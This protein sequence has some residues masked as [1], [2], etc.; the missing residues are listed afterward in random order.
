MATSVKNSTRIAGVAR[1]AVWRRIIPAGAVAMALL[2]AACGSSSSSGSA[3]GPIK[4][5]VIF[6]LS[7]ALGQGGVD[8]LDGVKIAVNQV[9]AAGGIG[10]RKVTLDVKDGPDPATAASAANKLISSDHVQ[11]IIGTVLS[12]L[13]LAAAPVANRGKVIYWEVEAVANNLTTLGFKYLFRV[14]PDSDTLGSL[15]AKYA[16]QT[17][18]PKLSIAPGKLRVGVISVTGAYGVDT[19][20]GVVAELQQEGVTPVA[21][22]SYDPTSTNLDS[23]ILKLKQAKP[24]IIVATSYAPDSILFTNE[25]KQE[26]LHYKALVGTGAGQTPIQFEQG[27]KAQANGILS[28]SFAYGVS[29]SMLNA[30]AQKQNTAF[31]SA[32]SAAYG[33]QPDIGAYLA[34]V[35]TVDLLNVLKK[36]GSPT[37]DAVRSAALKI[38]QPL[39]SSVNGWGLKFSPTGQNTL[40]PAVVTEW[41]NE[42]LEVISPSKAA[43]AQLDTSV[44]GH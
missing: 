37:P 12:D 29:N 10:G 21:N 24:D 14:P 17:V 5:G 32:F 30:T 26:G 41:Q 33:H 25:A 28:S 20:H 35:G 23:M 44:L 36:A 6:P 22:L 8:N 9:N 38:D 16:V 34:Y 43:T 1:R 18:A 27:L 4:I 19:T 15:A 11:E 2:A 39:G 3:K 13:A 7:G 42:A 40:S 31:K